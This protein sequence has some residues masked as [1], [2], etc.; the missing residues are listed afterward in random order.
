MITKVEPKW[1]V[2]RTANGKEKQVKEAIE[3]EVERKK[4]KNTELLVPIEKVYHHKNGKKFLREK[5]FYPGYL[6]VKTDALGE[7]EDAMKHVNFSYGFLGNGRPDPLRESE[8]F[9]MLGKVDEVAGET[10]SQ[11]DFYVG[12]HVDITDGPFNSFN[13]EIQEVD[14]KRQ[15]LKVNVKIFGRNTPLELTFEQVQKVY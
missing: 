4:L 5:N 3:L 14:G 1:Y 10:N 11:F 9:K 6:F 2:I 15:R 13:G 7:V 8:I 12:E